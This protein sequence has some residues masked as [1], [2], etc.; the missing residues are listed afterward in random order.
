MRFILFLFDFHPNHAVQ[1]Y[2]FEPWFEYKIGPPEK[3][4]I[5][6]FPKQ[7][8]KQQYKNA[9]FGKMR[10]YSGIDL[11]HFLDY[12]YAAYPDKKEF[13]RFLWYEILEKSKSDI[14]QDR[15]LNLETALEWV[16]EKE[17]G[18]LIANAAASSLS[19]PTGNQPTAPEN[20]LS[21]LE[22]D[23]YEIS[24]SYAGKIAL[25][26]QLHMEKLIQL[27]IIISDLRAPGKKIELLFE[28]FSA[29]DI[30]AILRQIEVFGDQRINT[31]QLKIPPARDHLNLNDP[32]VQK[33]IKALTDFFF[34]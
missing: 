11:P 10:E 3:G 1:E 15:R 24:R 31:L 29:M 23:M 20:I 13:V 28:K 26:S 19:D 17:P 9:I 5:L 14:T 27:L 22:A 21:R 7:P 2:E 16:K 18:T 6:Y 30:A 25:N 33:L 34:S 4:P 12:H 8:N 32:K